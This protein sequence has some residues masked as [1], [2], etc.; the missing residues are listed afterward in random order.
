M[1]K[2]EVFSNSILKWFEQHGR[3]NLP[4]QQERT[5]YRVWVSE[6]MLQQTQVATVIPYFEAFMSRFPSVIVLADAPLDA[7]LG[8]WSG[9]GYYARARN[10]HKA[11]QIVRDTHGGIFPVTFEEVLA[12][13]GIGRSTAGAVLSL[14]LDQRHAILDGNVKRVLARCFAV[15]GWPGKAAVADQLWQYTEQLTP[16]KRVADFNQAMMDLGAGICTRSRPLCERCPL[17]E[18]CMALA[19][20]RQADY[21]GKK[22]RKTIPVRE[23]QMLLLANGANEF[24]LQRRP[25]TGIWG[26]LLSLP[27]VPMDDD[28]SLW[29][30]NNLG[31]SV[32]ERTRW[33]V[34]RHTFSHFHLDIT[35]VL[36]TAMNVKG[37]S[38]FAN[39]HKMSV[40][41]G[42]E[43]LW[44]K[45]CVDEGGIPAP[46]T[47]LLELAN[48]SNETKTD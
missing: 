43:W 36:V 39:N 18:H 23:T 24:M 17:N 21:P 10:L 31:F 16:E 15:P 7:V 29:C 11:A 30:E 40:M 19:Q 35:P 6:I 27:E 26:G 47:R 9:L 2:P 38:E 3:K 46:V 12:L 4:W 34:M 20:Q 8:L 45:G 22:P 28:V 48:V 37:E 41:E 32:K 42:A 33:P 13:P 14:A 5:P 25:P 1:L 44:Y